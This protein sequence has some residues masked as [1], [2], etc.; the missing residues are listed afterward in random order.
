M[1]EEEFHTDWKTEYP[2][3]KGGK[4][5]E[6][7]RMV[8]VRNWLEKNGDHDWIAFDDDLFHS[9]NQYLIDFRL[10]IDYDAFK[11]ALDKMGD[12]NFE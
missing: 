10:G 9:T 3:P 4:F 6:H 1:K 12:F 11:W 8:A 7:P 2:Y 5:S